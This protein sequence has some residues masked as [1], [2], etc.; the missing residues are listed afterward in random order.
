MSLLDDSSDSLSGK[1][2][3]LAELYRQIERVTWL[4]IGGQQHAGLIG[5]VGSK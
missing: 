2:F 3:F 4:D 1:P 5:N